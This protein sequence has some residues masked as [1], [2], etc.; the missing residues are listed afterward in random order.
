MNGLSMNIF[1]LIF[2]FYKFCS[3]IILCRPGRTEW[4]GYATA[5]KAAA[6]AGITTIGIYLKCVT[7]FI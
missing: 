6:A 1:L 3:L 5:T 4:E 2:K 7:I